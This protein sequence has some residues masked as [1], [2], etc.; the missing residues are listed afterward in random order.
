MRDAKKR[1]LNV[2]SFYFAKLIDLSQFWIILDT[3]SI[4]RMRK[5]GRHSL[6]CV[7]DNDISQFDWIPQPGETYIP[8]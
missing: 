4:D 8:H 7:I 1:S 5:V 6:P 3:S 2:S